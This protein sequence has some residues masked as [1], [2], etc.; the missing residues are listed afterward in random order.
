MFCVGWSSSQLGICRS[1]QLASWQVAIEVRPCLS[2]CRRVIELGVF[3]GYSSTAIAL[4]STAF[5]AMKRRTFW[6]LALRAALQEVL[7]HKH[8][9]NA[10]LFGAAPDA[11]T[12]RGLHTEVLILPVRC[13]L[14]NG[15]G[16]QR[17]LGGRA[18]AFDSNVPCPSYLLG[19]CATC[20][21]PFVLPHHRPYPRTGGWWPWTRTSVR[22]R[23]PSGTGSWRA[24]ANGSRRG[25]ARPW[26]PWRPCW[27]GMAP[28]RTTW[29]SLV[30][31][32]QLLQP[33]AT[34]KCDAT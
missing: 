11:S 15:R 9:W 16:A 1:G 20:N 2:L 28:A 32:S 21:T 14:T 22:W 24:S 26:P 6:H 23:L 33:A 13:G 18:T 17:H 30:S 12:C 34:V 29:R 3:T 31:C 5:P 7:P 8:M 27:Q 25:W 4:V 19:F 10:P